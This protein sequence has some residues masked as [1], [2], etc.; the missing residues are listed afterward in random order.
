VELARQPCQSRFDPASIGKI[1]TCTLPFCADANPG[2]TRT[3]LPNFK[4]PVSL[5]LIVGK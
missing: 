4:K 2:S 5:F 1:G 3:Y